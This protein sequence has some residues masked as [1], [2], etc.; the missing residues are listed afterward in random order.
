MHVRTQY[1][2]ISEQIVILSDWIVIQSRMSTA[3]G[4]GV[5][6]C[7]ALDASICG[8]KKF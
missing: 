5:G 2:P 1:V 4:E 3:S 8:M 7:N 6:G